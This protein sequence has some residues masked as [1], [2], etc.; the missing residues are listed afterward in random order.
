AR[1]QPPR[2]A[3]GRAGD[4]RLD[5]VRAA[6]HGPGPAARARE[7]PADARAPVRLARNAAEESV[8]REGRAFLAENLP[9]AR[10]L[11]DEFGERIA[12]LRD[13]QRR[14]HA[15][16][17]VG[18]SWPREYGGRGAT[19]TEQIVVNQE[20]ARAGAPELIGAIGLD[21]IGPSLI[22]HGSEEQKR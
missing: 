2:G 14:L 8:A 17:L 20:L 22:A 18:L 12:F 3:A 11:P 13:W 1:A 15:A 6:Q 10:A 7:R 4:G 16:G 5:R 19:R 21:V 9:A